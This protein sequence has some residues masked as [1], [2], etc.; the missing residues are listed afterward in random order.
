MQKIII[1]NHKENMLAIWYHTVTII[2]HKVQIQQMLH[3]NNVLTVTNSKIELIFIA[4]LLKRQAI[5]PG[6]LEKK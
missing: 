2:G 3:T 5:P 4:M 6:I 1:S